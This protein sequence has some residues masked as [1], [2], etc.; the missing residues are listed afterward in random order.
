MNYFYNSF[1][2]Y[3]VSTRQYLYEK[4][5][6]IIVCLLFIVIY[7]PL[8]AWYKHTGFWYTMGWGSMA[9]TYVCELQ[10][11]NG[12][13]RQ[14][15][16]TLTNIFFLFF[17]LDMLITGLKD[18]KYN[19][20]YHNLLIANFQY[21]I[22][23]GTCMI[24]L[25]F[26]ST[27]YHASLVDTFSQL[28]MA[29]VFAC[30]LFPLFFTFHKLYAARFYNNKPY[31][32]LIGSAL[33]ILL[34]FFFH[35]I[36]SSYFW[37][38]SMVYYIIPLLYLMLMGSTGYYNLYYVRKSE[39]SLLFVSLTCAA[40]ANLCYFMDWHYCNEMS[41][42][43]PHAIWH[44]VSAFSMYYFYLFLRSEHNATLRG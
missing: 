40:I 19:K 32:S 20:G 25:F 22:V 43:Q 35:G 14:P 8:N 21:S 24:L 17:G 15:L 30:I 2:N 13:I 26:G 34:F 42:F 9:K 44:I 4:R 27:L 18:R 16:S 6:P 41:Y 29:G 7:Y 37:A 10:V 33:V 5:L 3:T 12:I 1:Y 28:D 11:V 23:F 39:R 38:D 36:L 31:F